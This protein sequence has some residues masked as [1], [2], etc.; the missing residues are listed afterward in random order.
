MLEGGTTHIAVATDHVVESFRNEMWDGYKTSAGVPEDLLGQFWPLEDVLR[1]LGVVTWAMT[2]LEADDALGSGAVFAAKDKRVEQVLICTPDK[3]V[4]QVVSGKRIVQ[5]DRRKREL[6]DE[7]GVVAKFGVSPASIPDYLGLVGDTSDGFP[8]LAGWGPK[9]ASTVLAKF[10]TIEA[11]PDSAREWKLTLRS[12]DSLAATLRDNRE[13]ALLFK[14][15]ATLRVEPPLIDDVE[16]LRWTGPT[17]TF[18]EL[19]EMIDAPELVARAAAVAT[20]L[21]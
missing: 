15:I 11:I 4:G 14:D 10:K 17:D 20:R 21:R 13:L 6:R 2:D 12:A 5:F 7:A 1:A 18:P 19:C 16:E 8:G 9:S 3:D